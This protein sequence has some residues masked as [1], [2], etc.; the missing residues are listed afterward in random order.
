MDGSGQYASSTTRKQQLSKRFPPLRGFVSSNQDKLH[1]LKEE[2]AIGA[3]GCRSVDNVSPEQYRSAVRGRLR[4]FH[5][6]RK[7]W[8]Q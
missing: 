5:R 6:K 4:R 3:N 1:L 2:S 8:V 7:N